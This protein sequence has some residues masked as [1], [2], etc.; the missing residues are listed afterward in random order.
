MNEEEVSTVEIGLLIEGIRRVH[1]VDFGGYADASLRRRLMGWCAT[2]GYQS[3]GQAI[4]LLLRDSQLCTSLVEGITVNVTEMFR[5]PTFFK[6]LRE[7]VVPHL[8]TYP[9]ARIWVAGC[10]TGQEVYS[11]AILL[12]E[13][14]MLDKCR[15]YATDLNQQVLEKAK[16]G[17]YPLQNMQL[18]TRNYQ[19]AGGRE[20]FSDYYVA[21]YERSIMDPSLIKNVIFATHNLATDSDFS[22]MQMVLSSESSALGRCRG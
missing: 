5:D 6:A 16:Q 18:Y 19:Q 8:R 20:S 21:R 14:G 11:L 1:G 2:S 9:H 3:I 13:E 17:I 12:Q 22:E 4:P 7:R 10:A 15:I